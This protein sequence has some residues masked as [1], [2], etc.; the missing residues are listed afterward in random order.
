[1]K[2]IKQNIRLVLR[3]IY[4]I[5]NGFLGFAY[6]FRR[7]VSYG[8]WKETLSDKEMR[9]YNIMMAYHGLEKSLSYKNRD[10]NAGWSAAEKVFLKLTQ[11]KGITDIGYHDKAAKEVLTTFLT[12]AVNIDK[13][14]AKQMLS[15]LKEL[16]LSS[17]DMHGAKEFSGDLYRQGVLANP[18][19]FFNSRYSLRE[20]KEETVDD[21]L[22]K[23]AIKL[24]MKTPS[25]CNRHA[26]HI[27]HASDREI[28]DKALSYQ[29]GNRPFGKKIPNLL[30]ITTDLKAFFAGHEHYQHWID[31]G[32]FSMSIMYALHSLG[33]A[34]CPL[35]WSQR[36]KT[37]RAL[38]KAIEIKPNHTVIM[39]MAL[40]YPDEFNKVCSSSRR[41]FEDIYSEMKMK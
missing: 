7:F 41:P 32:L 11:L 40:G 6:D 31:G 38:R 37:D 36:P 2:Q 22:V 35:N 15:A 23:R 10:P 26:W 9:N 21:E 28:I 33:L 4:R 19:A 1:M 29:N 8:G 17:E 20:Y 39:M 34:S 16:P 12:L 25:V 5:A 13:P 30:I 14:R 27:Y 18:E 3:G 24:A